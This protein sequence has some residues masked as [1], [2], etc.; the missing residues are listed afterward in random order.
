MLK[1]FSQFLTIV[2]FTCLG[3]L[4][5]LVFG[6]YQHYRAF[7][8]LYD[9]ENS[10]PWYVQMLGFCVVLAA[11]VVLSVILKLVIRGRQKEKAAVQKYIDRQ[12]REAPAAPNSEES[13]P[14]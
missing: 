14:S 13:D 6:T 1:K 11:V 12:S 7:A 9:R 8:S 3:A 10:A 2:I 4:A 5:G